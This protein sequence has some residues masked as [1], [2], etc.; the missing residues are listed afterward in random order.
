MIG[1][2]SNAWD[3]VTWAGAIY[4]LKDIH[5]NLFRKSLL[6][7]ALGQ[8]SRRFSGWQDVGY[9]TILLLSVLFAIAFLG[10]YQAYGEPER[11][12]AESSSIP[13]DSQLWE[14]S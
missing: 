10:E 14:D 3:A 5:M 4:R 1:V 2:R 11:G 6:Q 8:L 13:T 9:I 12:P 7:Q